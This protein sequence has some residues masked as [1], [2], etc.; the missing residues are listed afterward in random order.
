MATETQLS[1]IQGSIRS[2][3]SNGGIDN[4]AMGFI[5]DSLKT[6]CGE[7]VAKRVNS[8]VEEHDDEHGLR[9]HSLEMSNA[10]AKE[11]ADELVNLCV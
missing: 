2:L 1:V 11:F 7:V 3:R 10:E 5:L 6:D 8:R 4:D 9:R